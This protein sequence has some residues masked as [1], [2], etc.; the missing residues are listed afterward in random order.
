LPAADRQ[1]LTEIIEVYSAIYFSGITLAILPDD[2][3]EA[4]IDRLNSARSEGKTV[5][6]DSNIR[7]AL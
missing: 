6:F 1:K 4:L 7:P 5:A 2:D 3:V